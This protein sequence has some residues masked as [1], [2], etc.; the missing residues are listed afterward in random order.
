MQLGFKG[1]NILKL[2]QGQ[3]IPLVK[4]IVIT[5]D[6][7][8]TTIDDINN[9]SDLTPI[10][11]NICSTNPSAK[12]LP[13][14][15]KEYHK[16]VIALSKLITKLP[17][18]ISVENETL[19]YNNANAL[20]SGHM[21][22]MNYDLWRPLGVKVSHGGTT[23]ATCAALTYKY[24]DEVKG[25]AKAAAN[26]LTRW[27]PFP[28]NHDYGE[29]ALREIN[30]YRKAGIT[31]MLYHLHF[32]ATE[33]NVDCLPDIIEAMRYWTKDIGV[34]AFN[35]VS[36]GI[37]SEHLVNKAMQHLQDHNIK[38]VI[39]YDSNATPLATGGF[40][41]YALTDIMRETVLKYK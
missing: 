9:A 16:K 41:T 36:F 29:Q 21:T 4:R 12:L 40:W 24:K 3:G 11:L 37:P 35:E 14:D 15:L 18:N 27:S 10:S 19:Q 7:Y 38:L 39:V 28:I 20:I 13:T 8:S 31:D 30:I 33:G 32:H 22:L 26:F 17:F 5:L 23:A 34:V 6:G 1:T 2:A 25:N